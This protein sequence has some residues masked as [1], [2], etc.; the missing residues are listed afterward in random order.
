MTISNLTEFII[1]AFL[2]SGMM[3]MLV[4]LVLFARKLLLMSGVANL[5]INQS[6]IIN[7]SVGQKLAS[8]LAEN[9]IYLTAACGG[10][11]TCGQCLVKVTLGNEPLSPIESGHISLRQASQG[12]RLACMFKIKG[13]LSL[14]I[15]QDLIA[16]KR[17]QCRVVSNQLVSTY[18]TQLVLEPM[19]NER[20]EFQAGDYILLEA[21]PSLVSFNNFSIPTEYLPE[22]KKFG[23]LDLKMEITESQ[24]RA[25]SLANSPSKSRVI[26]LLVRIAT[27]P[28]NTSIE[29]PPGLVSSYIFNLKSDDRVSIIG[30]YGEF[31][32]RENENE[33]LFIGGGAGMAPLRAIIR[34]QLITVKSNRQI[35]FWY[36]A[37]NKQQL[38]YQSEFD[39]LMQ[40]HDNF[41]WWVALSEPLKSDHWSG[42]IG[43]IHQVVLQKYLSAHPSPQKIDYYV[44]GPAVM[45]AAVITMLKGVGVTSESI[46][47]DDFSGIG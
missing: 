14:Q 47:I 21:Q 39:Q 30:P 45:S 19:E 23:L 40:Q 3:M 28:A 27:P 17:F 33:M 15:P 1:G 36:G 8:A 35:S 4:L 12:F 34:D 5:T 9:G 38:C 43:F 20:L 13:D 6:Q 24:V 46:F 32:S 11:G 16:K 18:M 25:Y 26:E 7:V 44:C 31:H 42:H 41:K 29:T 22:W 37:R 10:K 2:F